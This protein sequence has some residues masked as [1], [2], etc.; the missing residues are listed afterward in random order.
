MSP[1]QDVHPR[2]PHL[3][4]TAGGMTAKALFMA[5]SDVFGRAK[6]IDSAKA[7]FPSSIFFTL[8]ESFVSIN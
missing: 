5:L 2:E 4:L 1:F 6:A 8:V 7:S 3:T